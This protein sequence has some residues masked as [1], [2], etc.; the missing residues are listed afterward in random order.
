[1]TE[2]IEGRADLPGD[3][4][5]SSQSKTTAVTSEQ[6]SEG[7]NRALLLIAIT[8][9]LAIELSGF[10]LLQDSL[11]KPIGF[12]SRDDAPQS[13]GKPA[14]IFVSIPPVLANLGQEG[15]YHHLSLSLEVMT[16]EGTTATLLGEQMPQIRNEVV[17]LFNGQ[18][19]A[20][21]TTLE[22][23]ERIRQE[24]LERLRD[25]IH[26]EGGDSSSVEG[27]YFSSLIVESP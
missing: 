23:K 3:T 18:P 14:P 4:V 1:M 12:F 13:S 5:I 2:V 9:V 25:L 15:G 27:V 16:R 20:Y 22:G 24:V 8:V 26:E 11:G 17:A 7:L 19:L 10:Y 6:S 21:V